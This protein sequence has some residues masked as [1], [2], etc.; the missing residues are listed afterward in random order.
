MGLL[1][2]KFEKNIVCLYGDKGLKWLENLP[3]LV[4]SFSKGWDLSDL[5]VFDNLSYN[6]VLSGFQKD[7]AIVLKLGLDVENL[8]KEVRAL[9]YFKKVGA[10]EVIEDAEGALLLEYVK[11]GYSLKQ[12]FPDRD[13]ESVLI[14]SGVIH[15]L[16][17]AAKEDFGGFPTIR[18]W[19]KSLD[20]PCEM[21]AE[22]LG[23]ARMLRDELLE[24]MGTSIL[25]H[26]D[27]HHKNILAHGNE[28]KIIDPKGVVGEL[29]YDVGCFIR[30]PLIDLPNHPDCIDI[31]KN[32][33]RAFSKN[34][35]L[36]AQRIT[37]WCYV[38][39]MLSVVWAHEDNLDYED[40]SQSLVYFQQL[41]DQ[42]L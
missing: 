21:F 37:K 1:M 22:Q 23:R 13:E 11:P 12:F 31:L 8:R 39:T 19:L 35:S 27:L 9:K 34:L 28:W 10:V 29:A 15:K 26:G 17:L 41:L 2:L 6:Y 24:T 38:Q 7:K 5:K 40:V 25:L 32:R 16:H 18:D 33:I 4:S 36:D 30:N 3:F 20:K 42:N 14:A